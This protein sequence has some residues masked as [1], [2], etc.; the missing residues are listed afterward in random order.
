MA[1]GLGFFVMRTP[2]PEIDPAAVQTAT[3]ELL[4]AWHSNGIWEL[5]VSARD[6]LPLMS[7]VWSPKPTMVHPTHVAALADEVTLILDRADTDEAARRELEQVRSL[8][9]EVGGAGGWLVTIG[10]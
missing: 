5:V 7:K 6:E 8:C 9:A 1:R 10:P 3:V 4:A 2:Y